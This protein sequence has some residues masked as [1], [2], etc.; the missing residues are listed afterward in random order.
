MT[1]LRTLGPG[2]A[3]LTVAASM[4]GTGVFTTTGYLLADTGSPAAVLV[5]WAIGGLVALGGALCY[6]ELG[7]AFPEN[8]GEYRLIGRVWHPFLGFVA[9]VSSL[10]VGFAAPVAGSGLAFAAYL[11]PVFPDLPDDR[12]AATVLIVGCAA[13]H[14]GRVRIGATALTT[15]TALQMLTLAVLTT[16]GLA[17]GDPGNLTGGRPL[18][19]AVASPAFAVGLV[20]VGYAYS[21]WNAAAYVA[22]ELR[23][24][25]PTLP[26]GLVLGTLGVTVLYLGVNAAI[27]MSAPMRELAGRMDV[28]HVAATALLGPGAG[29]VLSAVVAFGLVGNVLALL[30]TGSRV[31]EAVGLDQPRLAQLRR[32]TPDAGPGGALLGLAATALVIAWLAAF[33]FLLQ[34]VGLVLSGAAAVAVTGV[35][36]SRWREPDLVRPFR[37][38]GGP[39]V[40][41]AFLIP[42]LGSMAYTLYERPL[43]ALASLLTVGLAAVLWVVLGL[44]APERAGS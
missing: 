43:A 4:V 30:L 8:G 12:F 17:L 1:H 37:V 2:T 28:A 21:G 35:L 29:A 24:P 3:A 11:R 39:L 18:G 22:G 40:V 42:T 33:D 9:A 27:L 10:V 41:A 25:H 7:A 26:I 19:L 31:A 20:Y 44:R 15:V 32:T 36:W 16:A 34:W 5:A 23:D 6:A 13:V 14:A 38:P